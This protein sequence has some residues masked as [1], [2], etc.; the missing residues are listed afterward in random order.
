MAISPVVSFI[1]KT[2]ELKCLRSYIQINDNT[3][4]LVENCR[5][6]CECTDVCV[7]ILTSNFEVELWGNDL[8]L[9]SYSENS[10]KICGTIEQIRLISQKTRRD[11]NDSGKH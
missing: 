7:R 3:S 8:M 1:G 10:V 6:I 2:R 11:N 9:S 5:Q 4:A